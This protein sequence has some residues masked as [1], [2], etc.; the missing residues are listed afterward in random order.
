VSKQPFFKYASVKLKKVTAGPVLVE[1]KS[2]AGDLAE[3]GGHFVKDVVSIGKEAVV[4]AKPGLHVPHYLALLVNCKKQLAKEFAALA[5]RHAEEPAIRDGCAMF[6]KWS[7]A[8]VNDLGKLT[9][10]Y[11]SA[12]VADAK[13]PDALTGARPGGL[14]LLRDL[15]ELWLMVN[16]AHL[17]II[18]LVQAARALRDNEMAATLIEIGL[19]T[20]RQIAWI[21]THIKTTAPQVLVVPAL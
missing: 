14:G 11:G 18:I 16:N 21:D 12:S 2:M 5:G 6:G 7:A 19:E 1:T 3:L 10:R 15:H 8:H 17:S 9:E 13:A 4:P 20:D